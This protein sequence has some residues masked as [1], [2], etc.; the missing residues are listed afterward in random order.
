M[1]FFF[2]CVLGLVFV[3]TVYA[4]TPHLKKAI[5][6]QPQAADFQK[7]HWE[8]KFS[9]LAAL[10][11]DTVVLQWTQYGSYRFWQEHPKWLESFLSLADRYG[12]HIVVGL[13][14]DKDYFKRV[15]DTKK[16]EYY[17]YLLA[18]KNIE[19]AK[20]LYPQLSQYK[21]FWGW[22]I[23]DELHETLCLSPQNQR[24]LQTYLHH[25]DQSLDEL[26]SQK[27]VFISAFF[28]GKDQEKFITSLRRVIP[29]KWTL[30]LQ[31]G[32]GAGLT[33]LSLVQAYYRSF[34]KVYRRNWY[35]IVELFQIDKKHQIKA[36]FNRYQ[37]QKVLCTDRG[38]L[39]F[40]WRYLFTPQFLKQY[41][42]EYLRIK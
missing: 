2:R 36:D 14:A 6:Y 13:Y 42:K 32:M 23:Y 28:A 25:L 37:Q 1:K 29:E 30:L 11:F 20:T 16:L 24:Y 9:L 41:Q 3:I 38:Y 8:Q 26:S 10:G 12:M 17:L 4:D 33:N 19:T 34:D 40:S 7:P 5:I 39:L 35:P 15:K 31:S 27:R 21:A 18:Q 22:Y